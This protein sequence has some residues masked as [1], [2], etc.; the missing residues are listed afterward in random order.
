MSDELQVSKEFL[1]TQLCQTMP[2]SK[3]GGPYP[4]QAKKARRNEV[5]RLHFDYGYSARKIA[6]MMNVSRNTANSD[7]NYWY[8]R[9]QQEFES[10]S[11]DACMSKIV[12]RLESQS[13]LREELDKTKNLQ[14]KIFINKMLLD[15]DSRLVQFYLKIKTTDDAVYDEATRRLNEWMKEKNDNHRFTTMGQLCSF[16][17]NTFEKIMKAIDED[18]VETKY[19]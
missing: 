6:D 17:S 9:L 13:R 2:K 15:I 1:D 10:I 14:E 18:K 7:V 16:S 8:S 4:V 11:P 19:H 12:N 5:F 3:K